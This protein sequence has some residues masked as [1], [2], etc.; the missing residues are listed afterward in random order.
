M[1]AAATAATATVLYCTCDL[2]PWLSLSINA[3]S[4]LQFSLFSRF[5]KTR[6]LASPGGEKSS[7]TLVVSERLYEGGHVPLGHEIDSKVS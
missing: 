1:A 4:S 5:A 2:A 6:Y 7:Y 3:S